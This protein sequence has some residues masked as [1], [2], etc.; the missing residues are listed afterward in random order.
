MPVTL[1]R[2]SKLTEQFRRLGVGL[3][4][5]LR[6]QA[7]FATL[8]SVSADAAFRKQFNGF[9]RIGRKSP[10]WYDEFYGLFNRVRGTDAVFSDVLDE[11]KLRTG[12]FE[13]SF[14]S[15]LVATCD[16]AKPV[17]DAWV[18]KNVS[19]RLPHA[20]H[21]QRSDAIKSVYEGLCD[22]FEQYLVSTAG[23]TLVQQFRRAHP[24][25]QVTETKM[26]DLVLWQTR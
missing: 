8:T 10:E 7:R 23:R 16:P 25:A 1:E 14:A 5:Y 20:G 12:T 3:Q 9:Y 11:L 22:D 26:L 6:I 18:L 19:R 2:N 21:R 17:I 13:A 24:N 4:K 15:K